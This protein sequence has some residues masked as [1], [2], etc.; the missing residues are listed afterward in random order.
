MDWQRVMQVATPAQR[1]LKLATHHR[2]GAGRSS[3]VQNRS[4]KDE[5]AKNTSRSAPEM[6]T[7]EFEEAASIHGDPHREEL[8][9]E[10]STHI[11][12][13]SRPSEAYRSPHRWH[14]V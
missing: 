4:K 10:A 1:S 11:E 13:G 7:P 12:S 2:L 8:A 6:E 5:A 14:G 3:F 9:V